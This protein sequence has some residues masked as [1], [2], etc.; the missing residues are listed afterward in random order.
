[1]LRTWV[2]S[3]V[4]FLRAGYS[5]GAPATGYAP[6]LALLPR[7]LSDDEAALVVCGLIRR[8]PRSLDRAEIGVEII[9]VTGEMASLDDIES[10][11]RLIDTTG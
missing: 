7:K 9:R 1:M 5:N 3:I 6:L 8:R 11:Q 4:A 10:V 2:S